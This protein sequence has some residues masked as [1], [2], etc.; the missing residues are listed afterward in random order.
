[1][2]SLATAQRALE[3]GLAR[4]REMG[5]PV[6]IVVVDAGGHIVT[7]GRMD[8]ARFLTIDIAY[9]KAHG[10]VGFHRTGQE[11]AEWAKTVP[12]FASALATASHGGFFPA[13]GSIRIE[14]NGDEIGA[15]GVSGGSGEQ[16]HE[17]A[18]AGVNAMARG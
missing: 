17:I 8:G 15:I 18:Q 10:C 5:V 13:M 12:A 3:A 4:A 2:L 1:M 16:D 11:L 14:M 7:S 6:S 9:G